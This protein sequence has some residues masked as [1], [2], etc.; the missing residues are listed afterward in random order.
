MKHFSSFIMTWYLLSLLMYKNIASRLH[1]LF[2][3][4]HL[5]D[6]PSHDGKMKSVQHMIWE[7]AYMGC[8]AW[9]FF[10]NIV[11]AGSCQSSND[12][13]T[14]KYLQQ[15]LNLSGIFRLACASAL[16]YIVSCSSRQCSHPFHFIPSLNVY[17]GCSSTNKRH[18]HTHTTIECTYARHTERTRTRI[19]TER[20]SL[21]KY[22]LFRIN[23]IV[24]K[25]NKSRFFK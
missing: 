15:P 25:Y 2:K 23:T 1:S 19:V 18:T 7:A 8:I 13:V 14:M 11:L 12:Y 6:S 24:W 10:I 21:V 5:S 20:F 3:D 9:V 16:H 4:R 17:T 22:V